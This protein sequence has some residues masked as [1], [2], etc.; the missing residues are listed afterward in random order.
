MTLRTGFSLRHKYLLDGTLPNNWKPRGL[1]P[2]PSLLERQINIVY[3]ISYEKIE[4]F[5]I[6]SVLKRLTSLVLLESIYKM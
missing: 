1:Q 4:L 6:F 5:T 2:L 3:F